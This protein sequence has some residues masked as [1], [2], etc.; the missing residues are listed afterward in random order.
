MNSHKDQKQATLLTELAAQYFLVESNKDSLITVTRTEMEDRGK[1]ANILFTVLPTDKQDQAL[2]FALRRRNDFR[3]F[4][5]SKK[6]FGFAPR[7]NFSLDY[8][9]RNRQRIDELSNEMRKV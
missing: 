5:M 8:G 1:R 4:I 7:I 2:E 3:K 9:E 6:I